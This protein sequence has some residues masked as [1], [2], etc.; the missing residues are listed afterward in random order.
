MSFYCYLV[1]C[2]D[3]SFYT[4]WCR[5]PIKRTAA[6]N[7]GHGARYTRVHRPVRLVYKEQ[8]PD[9][10]SA[11]KRENAIKRL[12]HEQKQRLIAQNPLNSG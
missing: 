11:Q 10:S 9:R 8:M 12:S 7:A 2:S 5:D 3:G 4:G 6:H 1:E